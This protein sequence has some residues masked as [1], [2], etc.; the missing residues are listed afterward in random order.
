MDIYTQVFPAFPLKKFK[1]TVA[2]NQSIIT[3]CVNY[4]IFKLK[5]K[6]FFKFYLKLS[7]EFPSWLILRASQ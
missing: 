4:E 3:L 7:V 1:L 5:K 6:I 2:W